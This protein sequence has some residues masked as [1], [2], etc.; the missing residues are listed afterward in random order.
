MNIDYKK[1]KIFFFIG[2]SF[3]WEPWSL[4]IR[5]KWYKV[6]HAITITAAMHR[7]R[8]WFR[9]PI[10]KLIENCRVA[11][12]SAMHI[13]YRGHLH[14]YVNICTRMYNVSRCT[15]DF[16]GVYYANTYAWTMHVKCTV[17]HMLARKRTD[18]LFAVLFDGVFVIHSKYTSPIFTTSVAHEMIARSPSRLHIGERGPIAS[19]M[20]LRQIYAVRVTV[21]Y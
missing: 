20:R 21:H 13:I 3:Y 18:S 9:T 4:S 14:T 8:F 16:A 12:R 6:K 7:W 10:G 1:K 2:R 19:E 17:S 5:N 15:Y 11:R